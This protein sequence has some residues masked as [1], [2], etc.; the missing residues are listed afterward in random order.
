MVK[1]IK[2]PTPPKSI[3]NEN[4]YRNNPNLAVLAEDCFN[5]CY[6]C[7]SKSSTLNVEHRI[8]HKGNDSLKYDWHNLFLS[9]GHCNNIKAASYDDILNPTKCD[10]EENISLSLT[11]NSLVEK[12]EVT[13]LN[14]DSS[15]LQT[16]DLLAKVYNGGTTDMKEIECANLRNSISRCIAT[17]LQYVRDYQDEPDI[18]YDK[19]I[20]KEI[21][22]SSE[23]AAFKRK[24]IRDDS[25]LSAIFSA[26]LI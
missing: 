5:K 1:L 19:I 18:G 10:P 23:F 15:T 16:A 20:T 14:N 12:V 17:F 26:S 2:R 3:A 6:I 24:I 7:E 21:S 22:R 9:C 8:P 25:T 11:T 13:A 4:D